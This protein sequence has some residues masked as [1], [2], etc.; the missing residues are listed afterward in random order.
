[1]YIYVYKHKG[2]IHPKKSPKTPQKSSIFA[3]KSFTYPAKVPR[4]AVKEPNKSAKEPYK[5]AKEP[6]IIKIF[7]EEWQYAGCASYTQKEP[8]ISANEPYTSAKELY[9]FVKEPH[10]SAK[11]PDL[12]DIPQEEWQYGLPRPRRMYIVRTCLCCSVLE[13]VLQRVAVRCRSH[14]HHVSTSYCAERVAVCCSVR[15]GMV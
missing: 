1:M 4:I 3:Q 9:I 12:I 15:C 10:I 5:F 13:S 11:E 2:S 8:N 7:Q 6:Y 14:G